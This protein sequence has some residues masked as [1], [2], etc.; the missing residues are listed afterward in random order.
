MTTDWYSARRRFHAHTTPPLTGPERPVLA[1]GLG[2][3]G[4]RRRAPD[5]SRRWPNL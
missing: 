5:R 3:L 1:A 4:P 2:A